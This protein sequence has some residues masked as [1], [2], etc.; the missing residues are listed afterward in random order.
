MGRGGRGGGGEGEVSSIK[1]VPPPLCG[2]SG[3]R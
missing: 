2:L 3:A 1:C